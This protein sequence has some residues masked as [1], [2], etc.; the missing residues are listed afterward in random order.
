MTAFQH[1][2]ER[3]GGFVDGFGRL[4][5]RWVACSVPPTMTS[6]S[7]AARAVVADGHEARPQ[8]RHFVPRALDRVIDQVEF[9]VKACAFRDLRPRPRSASRSESVAASIS[10]RSA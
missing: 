4:Q 5:D 2:L 7:R 8:R 10:S 3:V 9:D 1:P 6:S